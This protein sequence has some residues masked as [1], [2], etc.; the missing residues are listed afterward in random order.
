MIFQPEARA[1]QAQTE[2]PQAPQKLNPP[3]IIGTYRRSPVEYLPYDSQSGRVADAVAALIRQANVDLHVEHIGSTAV[4]HCWGK[5]IIDLLVAYPRG[6]LNGARNALDWIGFQKQTGTD[7][8]PESRPMRVG[9]ME[10]FG[11]AYRIHAHVIERESEAA[12]ALIRFRDLLR[13][14][15]DLRRAYERE[16]RVILARGITE[17]ADYSKAKGEFIRR[18]LGTAK[19]GS[20]R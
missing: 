6:D 1:T 8:F 18:A 5:G 9:S 2:F 20:D 12:R 11:R 17:G 19:R 15:A 14:D 7:A 16:K 3:M 4:P 13:E 10:Y